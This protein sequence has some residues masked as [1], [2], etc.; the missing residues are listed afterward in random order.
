MSEFVGALFQRNTFQETPIF[1]GMY[2]TSGT[3]EGRPI[4]RVIGGMMRAFN[5]AP[6]PSSEGHTQAESKSYFVTD[7]FRRVVFPDQ[8]VAARTQGELRRQLINRIIF[9][10]LALFLALLI[11]VPSS[12]A[13]FKNRD[14]I[15]DSE[16]VAAEAGKV[17]WGDGGNV[18][19]KAKKLNAMR[20]QLKMLDD[21]NEHSPPLAYW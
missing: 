15:R 8:N 20:D 4:D 17:N 1:R 14:L 5:I 9:A 2:F 18:I 10:A 3:Q 19:D 13:F 12:C 11:V 16:A 6:M 7:L 21:W